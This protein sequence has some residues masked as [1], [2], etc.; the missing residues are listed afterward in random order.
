VLV[1]QRQELLLVLRIDAVGVLLLP[2]S[3]MPLPRIVIYIGNG[4]SSIW[5]TIYE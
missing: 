4:T 1:H 2:P 5:V 3:G